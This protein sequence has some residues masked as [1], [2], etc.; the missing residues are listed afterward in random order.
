MVPS[1]KC[2]CGSDSRNNALA[3]SLASEDATQPREVPLVA[4]AGGAGGSR[5]TGDGG[6]AIARGP[7]LTFTCSAAHRRKAK[8][9]AKVTG[10]RFTNCG[11][12]R[13]TSVVD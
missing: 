1:T 8:G 3:Q 11:A 9:G 4:A 7:R 6:G 10:G 13:A 5:T 12:E 2:T